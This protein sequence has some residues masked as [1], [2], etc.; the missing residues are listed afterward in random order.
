MP[1]GPETNVGKARARMTLPRL[2]NYLLLAGLLPSSLCAQSGVGAITG[3]VADPTGAAIPGCDVAITNAATG[4]VTRTNSNAS[5]TYIAP[6]LIAG[7]YQVGFHCAGFAGKEVTALTLRVGQQLRLDATLEVG[8][9]TQSVEVLAQGEALQ[10]ESAELSQ[11]LTSTD[12]QNLPV[13]GR[14][15]Y[16]LIQFTT[17]IVAGGTDPSGLG[18]S[19]Q[20]SING[21]RGRGNSFVI[22]GSSSL[23]IGGMGESIGSIEAFSEAKVLTNT[24]SAEFGRTAGGVVLFNVKNGTSRLHGSLFEFHRNSGLNA[25]TWQDNMLGNRIATRRIHQFGAT[26]GGPVPLYKNKLFFFA[27]YEGQRDHAPSSK[28]RTV[29]PADLRDGDFSTHPATINDPLAK[30][31]FAGNI[32]PRSRMDPAALK[33]IALLPQPNSA[34]TLNTSYNIY[35]DNYAYIGKTDWGRNFGIGRIDYNPTDKDRVFATFAYINERRDEGQDFPNALNYI[36]GATPRGMPRLT[37]TYTRLFSSTVSNELMAHA[38]R[39]NR[40]QHPWFGDFDARRDLGI[41]RSPALGMPTVET[42]GGWGNFGYSRFEE[43]I[44]QPAGLNDTLTHQTGRHTMRVGG[45]LFQNQFSYIS[46]GQVAGVY[47]FNGEITGLGTRG[48]NNPLNTWADLL[49]G[50]VKTA[51]VPVSQIPVTRT[52][53]NLGVFFNDTWKVSRR[54][55]LNLGLRY[56]F[57][58]RQIVKNNVYSRVDTKTG[59]LLVAG[60]NASRNLNLSNDWINFGPRLGA[61]YALTDKTV[62]Q[63]GYGVFHANFWIDNG[64]MV[65]YPGWTGARTWI[66]QGIGIAQPFGFADGLPVEGLKRLTDPFEE[67]RQATASKSLLTVASNTYAESAQLPRTEQWNIGVQQALPWNAVLHVAYVASRNTNQS[68]TVAANEPGLAQAEAV[69]LRGVRLQD[70]RPFPQYSAFN[71][72]LYN[73]YGEYHSLQ[74][75]FTRRFRRG[76]SLNGNFTF[77]KN[78]DSSSNYSDSHQI[79]WE[80]PGIEHAR[81]SLDRPR[82]ATFGWV[83]ELPFGRGKRFGGSNR[84][85]SAILGGFQWNGVLNAADGL[86][87]TITQNKQN[88]ILSVQRPNV[89]DPSNLSG[90]TEPEF[91]GVARRW[92]IARNAPGFPFA[93]S[94]NLGIGNLGRNTS[95]EPGHWNT[96]MSMFRTFRFGETLRLEMRGEAF[97]ALNHVNY[98]RPASGDITNLSYGLIT[99]AAPAR[100]IQL[101]LRLSF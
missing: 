57:E 101:G 29:A 41:Q 91:T 90:R 20:L 38:M 67:L 84:V 93:T 81:A 44:N 83:W 47:R 5:G 40:T 61:V 49:L 70:A 79:P 26:V 32:I 21:S 15:P 86:P 58:T 9:L 69:N 12:I 16:A 19:D 52:N 33:L 88:L 1:D 3:L 22:D 35:S 53:A 55:N 50:A 62:L 45:Q 39:D 17:G 92:L 30:A 7:P 73:A 60:R 37:L 75:K 14:D 96:N 72:I 98:R 25:G 80:L 77:S 54:L 68:R 23:H 42:T 34:G 27:S 8:N 13:N 11:T 24:Y 76:F 10:R 2:S 28:R 99:A 66:D 100:Q 56:E 71:S 64:E 94:G 31:P 18:Y 97:N 95:R 48:R 65:A 51:E 63:A 59:E 43:W 6:S 85:L 74:V 4:V 87:F 46:A 78:T 89:I 82:S 36:R